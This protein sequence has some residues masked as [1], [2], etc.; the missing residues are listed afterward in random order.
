MKEHGRWGIKLCICDWEPNFKLEN[1]RISTVF[2]WV[3]L[4]DLR[5]EYWD[6]KVVIAIGK[7]VRRSV[8]VDDVTLKKKI[9]FSA[10]ING[11]RLCKTYS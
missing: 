9:G 5:L 11:G 1:Q 3:R 2:I 4:P 10:N 6:E 7:G 8:Q